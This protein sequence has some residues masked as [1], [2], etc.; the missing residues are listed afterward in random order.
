MA[1]EARDRLVLPIPTPTVRPLIHFEGGRTGGVTGAP[2]WLWTD[3]SHWSPRGEP[4]TRRVQAGP[5][6]ATVSAAAVRMVWRPGDGSTVTC[7][8]AG[9]PLTDPNQGM[10]GSPDCGYTYRRT[11]ATQPGGVYRVQVSITWAVTWVGSDGT[12]GA[13]APLTVTTTFPY[14]VRQVRAQLVSPS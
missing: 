10:N 2:S 3:P 4:L 7:L 6:W 11:S 9:T 13:L 1:L 14:T 8:T 5:V 12:H